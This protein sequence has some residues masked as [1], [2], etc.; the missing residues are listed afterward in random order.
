LVGI[1]HKNGKFYAF[2]RANVGK[3]P[4]WTDQVAQGGVGPEFGDGTISPAAWDN[5]RLYI[6]GGKT[7]IHGQACQGSL[8]AVN[9]ATGAYIWEKCMM[10]GPVLGAVSVVPGVAAVGEGTGLVLVATA[11]G[12]TLFAAWDHSSN[13]QYYGPATISHGV[14]YNGVLYIGN[15]DGKLY[16]YGL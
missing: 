15:K 10:D 3:G 2:D 7:T 6:A 14:L 13:S 8:R 11:D 5:Q 4:I 16:A 9:P 12:S 1:G